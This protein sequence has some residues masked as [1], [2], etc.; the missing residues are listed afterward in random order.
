MTL[1][2]L[3]V[4][5]HRQFDAADLPHAFGG[6]LALAYVAEPRGT[7]D[8]D[9]N[10]FAMF[11]EVDAAVRVLGTLGLRAERPR[12]EWLPMAGIRLR[13]EGGLC[14]VDVFPSLDERYAEIERRCV[15][16][17]FGPDA[18]ELPFLSAEDL[19]LFKL[20]FG[21]DKDW[22]DLRAIAAS[23]PE[24][25]IDYIERQLIGLRGPAMHPRVAR[26]RG[27]RR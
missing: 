24:L 16:H 18:V 21:R 11:D 14:P 9:V 26:L 4:Q 7:V 19:A 27:M 20:S 12:S 5:V 8:I 6:A 10:V 22:V 23:V 13:Q 2:D 1:V 17:P 25:D 15:R 3:V